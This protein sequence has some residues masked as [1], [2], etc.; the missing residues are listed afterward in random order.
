METGEKSTDQHEQLWSMTTLLT[1]LRAK[2]CIPTHQAKTSG[3]CCNY[4]EITSLVWQ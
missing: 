1:S 2:L 4:V 3:Q